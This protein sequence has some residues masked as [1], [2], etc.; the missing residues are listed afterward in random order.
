M[1]TAH[2]RCRQKASSFGYLYSRF[3]RFIVV[4]SV[5]SNGYTFSRKPREEDIRIGV[6]LARGLAAADVVRSQPR[7]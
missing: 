4:V 3:S 1:A 5:C 6:A 2:E 7:R